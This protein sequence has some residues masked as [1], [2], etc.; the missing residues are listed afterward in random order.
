MHGDFKIVSYNRK[1]WSMTI[2]CVRLTSRGECGDLNLR[3]LGVYYDHSVI[4]EYIIY[5]QFLTTHDD[6]MNMCS[7]DSSRVNDHSSAVCGW[8]SLGLYPQIIG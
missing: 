6:H 1:S 7:S 4:L 8:D 5:T 2:Y 3:L